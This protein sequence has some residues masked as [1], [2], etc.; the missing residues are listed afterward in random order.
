MSARTLMLMGTRSHV[1][2]SVLCTGL[3][4]WFARKG[5]RVA[6]FKA[7][8]LSL[9]AAI[10]SAGGEVARSTFAQAEAAGVEAT[11]D[12]NPVLV[13]PEADQQSQIVVNG[14][15]IDQTKFHDW[16]DISTM[17]WKRIQASL[18]SL[19]KEYDLIIIEG[20]GSPSEANLRRND[21]A[22][23]RLAQHAEAP[24]VLVGDIELGGVFA[25]LLGT[26]SLL[27]ATERDRIKAMIINRHHGSPSLFGDYLDEFQSIAFNIPCLGIVPYLERVGVPAEDSLQPSNSLPGSQL[28]VAVIRYPQTSNFDE[29]EALM[30]EPEI[31]VRFVN[32]AVDLGRPDVMILPGSKST[33]DDLEWLEQSGIGAMIKCLQ[34]DCQTPVVGICGGFQMLG[35]RLVDN[36]RGMFPGLGLLPIMTTFGTEKETRQ[37]SARIATAC[38]GSEVSGTV[39]NGYELHSG[40]TTWS[41][42]GI[43]PTPFSLVQH[44]SSVQP[45][46]AVFEGRGGVVCGTYIHGLFDNDSFR[47][48]WL[49]SLGWTGAASTFSRS[50]CYDALADV[51]GEAIDMESLTQIIEAV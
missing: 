9:N 7:M 23:M 44:G 18:A 11:T 50:A 1:G 15:A 25:S 6:P 22:N 45:D 41:L 37:V 5:L 20:S 19:R 33:I 4:R 35:E 49:R 31:N 32:R 39:V 51:L 46:G 27:S 14:V 3:C 42:G 36:S 34:R 28:D 43:D 48:G 47:A 21:L 16:S 38:W 10:T 29:F 13:K 24:V 26:L 8:N 40:E 12:M 2:K 30:A 17:L